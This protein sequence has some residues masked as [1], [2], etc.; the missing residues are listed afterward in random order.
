MG[1][2]SDEAEDDGCSRCN[3]KGDLSYRKDACKYG[4]D[5]EVLPHR[6]ECRVCGRLIFLTTKPLVH[7]QPGDFL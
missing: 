2:S 5:L 4:C 3:I 1:C 6:K 7:S